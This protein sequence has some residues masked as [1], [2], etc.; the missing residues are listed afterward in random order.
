MTDEERAAM[1][2]DM[3]AGTPGPWI[4]DAVFSYTGHA[5]RVAFPDR[6]GQPSETISRCFQNWKDALCKE[7]RISWANAEANARRVARLPQIE[8]EVLA[9]TAEN[10]EL[11]ASIVELTAEKDQLEQDLS[12]MRDNAETAYRRGYY[13][14]GNGA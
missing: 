11:K 10:A 12:D 1:V 6:Y 5:T 14:G 7:Q 8:A 13:A 9:L 3:N 2:A 4:S